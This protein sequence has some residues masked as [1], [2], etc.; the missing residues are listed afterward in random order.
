[1]NTIRIPFLIFLFVAFCQNANALIS[2]TVSGNTNTVPSL[3]ASYVSFASAVSALNSVTA[4]NGPVT[5]NMTSGTTETAAG[6]IT[7]TQA[8]SALYPVTFQ[9]SGASAN[10]KLTRTDAGTNTTTGSGGF[11]DGVLRIDGTDNILF[12]GLDI[13]ASN[14]G[15]E[16]G[17]YVHKPSATNG[18]QNLTIKNATVTMTKGSSAYVTGIY[19]DNGQTGLGVSDGLTITSLSGRSVNITI[20]GNTIQNVHRGIYC[21]GFYG[22]YLVPNYMDQ[23]IYIGQ[24]GSGN[25]NTIINFGGGA[26]SETSGIFCWYFANAHVENN[27]VNN[28]TGGVSA[29]STIYGINLSYSMAVSSVNNN[30]ITLNNTSGEADWIR[31]YS[32]GYSNSYPVRQIQVNN[33]TFPAGLIGNATASSLILV[34]ITSTNVNISVRNNT[35]TGNISKSGTGGNL[36]GYYNSTN[37]NMMEHIAGNNFSNMSNGGSCYG[38]ATNCG[39][40]D[41]TY[42]DSNIVSNLSS[43][44]TNYIATGILVS[45]ATVG[46]IRDNTISNLTGIIAKGI[47]LNSSNYGGDIQVLRNKIHTLASLTTTTNIAA[48][49]GIYLYNY[50]QPGQIKIY[51]N[52]IG[53]LTAPSSASTNAING[54][55]IS[56]SNMTSPYR[57]DIAHNTIYFNASS[58]GLNFGSSGIYQYASTSAYLFDRLLLRNNII[59]NT[60]TPSGTGVT[61]AF[62]RNGLLTSTYDP[63]S[64]RNL[65]Y[66]GIP[67]AS[68]LIFTNGTNVYSLLNDYQSYLMSTVP[69]AERN[70]IS[71]LPAFVSASGSSVDFLKYD[72]T[73]P[74]G[75]ESG[76]SWIQ[77]ITNDISSTLRAGQPG[78]SGSGL[79]PDLGA[80]E[81]N[82]TLL[83]TCSGT[84]ATPVAM[85]S[86]TNPCADTIFAVYTNPIYGNG[87]T[88]QWQK[89]NIDSLTGFNNITGAT[90]SYLDISA[91][92]D[93]WYR[94]LVSC[95]VS[96]QSVISN[97]VAVD[98]TPLSGTYLI[99]N[100]GSGQFNSFAAAI[101]TLHCR[102]TSGPVTFEVA[103]GQIFTETS[104]LSIRYEG[105]WPVTF[106]KQGNGANPLIRRVGTSSTSNYILELMGA[107]HII[108]DGIDFEQTG[109]AASTWVE[110]GIHITNSSATDGSQ[111]NTFKNGNITM[112]NANANS[113]AVYC[114]S[115]SQAATIAAGTN[116][117]NRFVN[118]NILSSF[119]GYD[120]DNTS[121]LVQDDGNAVV[122]EN[123]LRGSIQSL[124]N[125]SVSGTIYGIYASQQ[126]NFTVDSIDVIGMQAA[127]YSYGIYS[128]TSNSG[129]Q[130][131][132]HNNIQFNSSSSTILGMAL[133]NLYRAKVFNNEVHELYS[134]NT[135][136]AA[137]WD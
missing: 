56:S 131:F 91:T 80:W 90:E 105:A 127:S 73:T 27:T 134:T 64:N 31:L 133:F 20:I 102:N 124:G 63:A 50:S 119:T 82:G 96:N 57:E 77:G 115:A 66:A 89:S 15:I 113:I 45:D 40:S 81:L 8:G 29:T 46:F 11:G 53:N 47:A 12:N 135:V 41:T 25:G 101:A 84:P 88:Y 129:L 112:S 16:Y 114:Q 48:V 85:V 100:T 43:T 26:A 61:A 79:A 126:K 60:S 72:I 38:I 95:T 111:Y 34:S 120:F 6:Q 28:I 5:F 130:T 86:M 78:Y 125:G 97:A 108:F 19:V 106:R 122:G 121:T 39:A 93:T 132:S 76:A 94:C 67:S 30:T 83:S 104:N 70:S 13:A 35:T 36:Y 18:S 23:D 32:Y 71:E 7:L 74:T 123:G 59:V 4:I 3:A 52:L 58:S 99:S 37:S 33:N 110:W 118:M 136:L 49:D 116:S 62:R 98:L 128:N 54:I 55:E 103:D 117:Y 51:N 9:K 75:I 68:N 137:L 87:T 109:T 10:P 65:F 92:T 22:Y 21:Y 24:A 17:Y 2:I 1:M 42:I 44:G 69:A 14:Q 107:D